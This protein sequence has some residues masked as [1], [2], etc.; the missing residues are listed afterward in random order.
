MMKFFGIN[1]LEFLVITVTTLLV[2]GLRT[3]SDLAGQLGRVSLSFSPA[4]QEFQNEMC[5]EMAI[6][7]EKYKQ[8]TTS[9]SKCGENDP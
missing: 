1:P 9:K 4:A 8:P 6:E 2:F 7:Q 5:R 3:L